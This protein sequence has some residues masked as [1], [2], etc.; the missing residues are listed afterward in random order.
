MSICPTSAARSAACSTPWTTFIMRQ[1]I[2]LCDGPRGWLTHPLDPQGE[3]P[4]YRLPAVPKP[5]SS[6]SRL[7]HWGAADREGDCAQTRCPPIS[8]LCTGSARRA[9]P[10]TEDPDAIGPDGTVRLRAYLPMA[11]SLWFS[12]GCQGR[13]GCGHSAPLGIRGAILHVLLGS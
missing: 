9:F 3:G 7:Q 2:G 13:Q 6:W 11:D 8:V 4:A 10:V 1:V 12:A 5:A